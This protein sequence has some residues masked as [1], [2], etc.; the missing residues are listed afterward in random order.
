MG[1]D[2]PSVGSQAEQIPSISGEEG[3]ITL[4][5]ANVVLYVFKPET[6]WAARGR[7]VLRLKQSKEDPSEAR[8]GEYCHP[9]SSISLMSYLQ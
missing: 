4:V 9:N 6:G 2:L 1:S 5:R 8:L 3:E 7:G